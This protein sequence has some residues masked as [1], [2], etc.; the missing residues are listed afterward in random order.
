MRCLV[1]YSS[2]TGNTKMIAEAIIGVMPEGAVLS[3]VE[4][5]PSPEGFDLICLGF[6]VDKGGPDG[7]MATYMKKVKEK[8]VGLFGTLGA[9]PDSDHARSCIDQAEAMLFPQNTVLGTF[10]CQGKIN[11]KILAAM[12]KMREAQKLHPMTEER[13]A[14]I[15]EAK[16]HPNAEDCADARRFFS[17][18]VKQAQESMYVQ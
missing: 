5:A 4:T 7:V 1:V 15:E 16:K 6:W 14:R 10:L 13:K 3:P 9:W 8:L 2:R 18:V 11:P 12:E 17:T